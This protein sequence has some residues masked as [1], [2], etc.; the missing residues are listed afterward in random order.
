MKV[1]FK[2]PKLG[3]SMQSAVISRWL[4]SEGQP[5]NKGEPLLE[6]ETEKV[7]TVLESPLSGT[8]T[9]ILAESGNDIAVGTAIA[10]IEG[11]I[12]S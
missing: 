9:K 10:E 11:S 3:M 8:L 6:I 12:S 2:M 4:K 7:E 5:V 1:T